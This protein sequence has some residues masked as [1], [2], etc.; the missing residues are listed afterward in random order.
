MKKLFVLVLSLSLF[1][2]ACAHKTTPPNGPGPGSPQALIVGK[3][4]L[5]GSDG[6]ITNEYTADGTFIISAAGANTN[7]TYKW[8]DDSTVET[9]VNGKSNTSKVTISQD[10]LTETSGADVF[11]FTRAGAAPQAAATTAAQA[12]IV[13]TWASMAGSQKITTQYNNDGTLVTTL[14]AQIN[15]GSY[16]WLD[17]ST[18]QLNGKSQAKIAISGDELTMTIGSEVSTFKRET[19][20]SQ[21]NAATATPAGAASITE[22]VLASGSTPLTHAPI[23]VTQTFPTTQGA[24]YAIVTVSNPPNGTALKGVLTAV[25]T[26]GSSPANTKVGEVD[27]NTSEGT[28][29]VAFHWTYPNLPAGKYKIDVYLNGT[30][31]KTLN[32]ALAKDAPAPPTAPPVS[33][34]KCTRPA[35][36]EKPPGFAMSVTMAERADAQGKPVNPGRTFQPNAS[37]ISAVLS[38]ENVPASSQI[39]VR[40][41]GTDL[42]GVEACNTQI[43]RTYEVTVG[44]GSSTP[45]FNITPPPGTTW[46]EGLYRAEISVNGVLA[47]STDFAVCSGQCK[48]ALPWS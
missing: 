21:G 40:W 38:V 26:N 42:G 30:V 37:Q 39:S 47:S 16:R 23:N 31:D 35:S 45:S 33:F 20:A 32:F 34:G 27:V 28:Q 18:I 11:K 13:G 12:L 29:N 3:W 1:C 48:F 44:A 7:G 2:V 46:P 14:G 41:M 9:V 36:D 25:D 5:S 19:A 4:E 15:H 10:Q 22:A 8:L 17:D 6:Q 24:I 43:V